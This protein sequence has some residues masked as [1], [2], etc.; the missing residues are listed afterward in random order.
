MA[1]TPVSFFK[2]AQIKT[3]T[4]AAEAVELAY[5][6]WRRNG[7]AAD[8]DPATIHVTLDA[9]NKLKNKP[10]GVAGLGPDGRLPA[11]N[12]GDLTGTYGLAKQGRPS[13]SRWI[14][15]GDS[16]TAND[17]AN[18][19]Y[20]WNGAWF[21][22]I[23]AQSLGRIRKVDAFATGGFTLEQI[24]ATHL[25]TALA[26]SPRPDVCIVEGGTNNTGAGTGTLF[27]FAA[28][29]ATHGRIVN[30]LRAV[31]IIPVVV[32]IPPRGDGSTLVQANV[33]KWNA[34]V[35]RYA[36]DNGLSVLDMFT[37]LVDPATG[38]YL[39]GLT[40]G[41]NVHPS[42]LGDKAI[43]DYALTVTRLQDLT[44]PSRPLPALWTDPT[45]LIPSGYG[46]NRVD[47]N[48]D[49]IADGWAS[50]GSGTNA[51]FSLVTPSAADNLRGKWQQIT[52]ATGGTADKTLYYRI[53]SG[54]AVGDKLSISVRFQADGYTANG[55]N[56]SV[57]LKGTPN[58]AYWG[59]YLWT[60]DCA[61]G[62]VSM[63]I[64]IP[65]DKT[66]L[67]L[68]IST[69]APTGAGS[70][71]LRAGEVTVRNLTALGIA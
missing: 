1:F 2:G 58:N 26:M 21:S 28:A 25:P 15:I 16:I 68:Q 70:T 71:N 53:A 49:G 44:P 69:N 32:L 8:P 55:G 27:D 24:E 3:A 54:W 19:N 23:A 61:D 10:S 67:D 52:R 60:Q 42:R 31:G 66:T 57:Q 18:G 17:G 62:L 47:T 39:A 63:D 46:L 64:V 48:A 34:Y 29:R 43:A 4:T 41:D 12:V 65:S 59:A 22:R 45:N 5:D 40:L 36:Q 20:A 30:A 38:G 35:N 11:A 33:A 7:P 14:T 9:L 6:G 37:P 56:Y 13:G 51:T 50:L